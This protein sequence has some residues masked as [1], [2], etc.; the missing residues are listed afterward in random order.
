[1][2]L[3]IL[4]KGDFFYTQYNSFLISGSGSVLSVMSDTLQATDSDIFFSGILGR[5]RN[6]GGKLP[7]LG[8]ILPIL[9][10]FGGEIL[11]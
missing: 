11:S 1:M 6:F 4:I 3:V 9:M 8:Y 7:F 10:G 2:C 5:I